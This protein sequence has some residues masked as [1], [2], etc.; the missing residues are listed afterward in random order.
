[1]NSDSSVFQFE[2][3]SDFLSANKDLSASISDGT[4]TSLASS[5]PPKLG[6]TIDGEE[7]ERNPNAIHVKRYIIYLKKG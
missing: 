4:G 5:I 6:G 1:M 3:I 7:I 2:G